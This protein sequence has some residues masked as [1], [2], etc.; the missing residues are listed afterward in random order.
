MFRINDKQFVTEPEA[1]I[2]SAEWLNAVQESLCKVI[3]AAGDVIPK[4]AGY[5]SNP[6]Y[7]L[8]VKS[9][10]KFIEQ[11]LK[12]PVDQIVFIDPDTKKELVLKCVGGSRT[13]VTPKV[14]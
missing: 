3:E 11:A 7:D 10:M 2:V 9:I 4:E 1:T 14:N 8:L 5:K 13:S 6:K 12:K